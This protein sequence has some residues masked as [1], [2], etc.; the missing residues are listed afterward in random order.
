[1]TVRP[2][3]A[4][5]SGRDDVWEPHFPGR[6]DRLLIA[7]MAY[8]GLRRSELLGLECDDIDLSRRLLQ[9]R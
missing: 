5:E 4:L 9:V 7:L 6:S 1:M 2:C 8:A 3:A